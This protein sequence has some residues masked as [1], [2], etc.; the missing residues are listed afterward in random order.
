[1][2]LR[3]ITP[4]TFCRRHII[5]LSFPQAFRLV[6]AE[7]SVYSYVHF[8]NQFLLVLIIFEILLF[9][10]QLLWMDHD[11]LSYHG[12]FPII[13]IA[14]AKHGT[15]TKQQYYI[16]QRLIYNRAEP[17]PER[18]NNKSSNIPQPSSVGG[19]K[20]SSSFVRTTFYACSSHQTALDYIIYISA[21]FTCAAYTYVIYY[22]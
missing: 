14:I 8:I 5:L 10:L 6:T 16:L 2:I 22:K 17:F 12:S 13:H 21:N 15:S 3:N 9:A 7:V 11:I 20:R 4:S 18:N 1:M 19:T